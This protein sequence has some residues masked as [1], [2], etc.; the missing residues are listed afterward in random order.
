MD[1]PDGSTNTAD[2]WFESVPLVRFVHPSC[3]ANSIRL[4]FLHITSSPPFLKG[5]PGRGQLTA[6]GPYNPRRCPHGRESRSLLAPFFRNDIYHTAA[7]SAEPGV[8]QG[9]VAEASQPH[10]QTHPVRSEPGLFQTL[11]E[12]AFHAALLQATSDMHLYSSYALAS[13]LL[14]NQRALKEN[15][16][17]S[18]RA[19]QGA[20]IASRPADSMCDEPE[21][22]RCGLPRGNSGYVR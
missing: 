4:G 8:A 7:P 14:C 13:L 15:I 1:A 10:M 12:R 18:T 17:S 16:S 6:I 9:L 22:R 11:K 2:Y 19:W 5:I 20:H 3:G 21:P